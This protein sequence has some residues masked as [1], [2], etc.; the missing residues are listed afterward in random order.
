M[1]VI[2]MLVFGYE[3]IDLGGL[4]CG[5]MGLALLSECSSSVVCVN[6]GPGIE[7]RGIYQCLRRRYGVGCGTSGASCGGSRPND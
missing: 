6:G 3:I 7:L 2:Q 4:V 1:D 5:L